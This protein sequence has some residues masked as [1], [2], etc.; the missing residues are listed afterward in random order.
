[1]PF[2]LEVGAAWLAIINVIAFTAFA[3]DK[4]L[5]VEGRGRIP[6]RDLLSLAMLGGSVGAIAAQQ[7]MRHK[8]RKEPFRSRLRAVALSQAGLVA[9]IV[10][11]IAV[12]ALQT[13]AS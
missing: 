7:M 8:T 13:P 12:L 1:M 6:E 2:V 3:V 4:Q 5:A 11:S 9:V 10:A